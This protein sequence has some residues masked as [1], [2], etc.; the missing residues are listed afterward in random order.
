PGR[1]DRFAFRLFSIRLEIKHHENANENEERPGPFQ[2]PTRV[3]QNL[4]RALPKI[5][6]VPGGL[7]NFVSQSGPSPQP[8]TGI[9]ERVIHPTRAGRSFAVR[10]GYPQSALK[11][12]G[13]IAA[14]VAFDFEIEHLE[15]DR[16][17]N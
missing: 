1:S 15:P 8:A 7:R 16:Q 4:D 14:F 9:A 12:G 5:L 13:A 2:T 3:P 6:R 10:I 17:G 11:S